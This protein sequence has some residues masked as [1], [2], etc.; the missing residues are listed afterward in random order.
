MVSSRYTF[1]LNSDIKERI[2]RKYYYEKEWQIRTQAD[3]KKPEPIYTNASKLENN[4]IRNQLLD[5]PVKRS[6]AINKLVSSI[7]GM[8]NS[9]ELSSLLKDK[10]NELADIEKK[11]SVRQRMDMIFKASQPVA[12][13]TEK[14]LSV[15]QWGKNTSSQMVNMRLRNLQKEKSKDSQVY[16]FKSI[17]S[18]SM[19][20]VHQGHKRKKSN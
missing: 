17:R 8:P 5:Q 4:R 20:K 1:R 19:P 14:D 3:N 12:L 7:K 6:M 18:H 9:S 15:P 16:H 11:I 13:L 10:I 2:L